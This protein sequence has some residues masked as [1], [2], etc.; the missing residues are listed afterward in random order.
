M[1]LIPQPTGFLQNPL[2]QQLFGNQKEIAVVTTTDAS[3]TNTEQIGLLAGSLQTA[4]ACSD[5]LEITSPEKVKFVTDAVI[6]IGGANN[7]EVDGI[8]VAGSAP[9]NVLYYDTTNQRVT[10]GAT[11]PLGSAWSSIPVVSPANM[12]MNNNDFTN[13]S[14]IGINPAGPLQTVGPAYTANATSQITIT[15]NTSIIDIT[16]S[17]ITLQVDSGEEIRFLAE[18]VL[19]GIGPGN[20]RFIQYQPT[21]VEYELFSAYTAGVATNIANIQGPQHSVFVQA[22]P[23][24]TIPVTP[25]VGETYLTLDSQNRLQWLVH[26]PMQ[27]NPND[28]FPQNTQTTL[29]IGATATG[30]YRTTVMGGDGLIYCTPT[31]T[32]PQEGATIDPTTD[33]VTTGVYSIAASN[34]NPRYC[35]SAGNK[36]YHIP[37]SAI[38]GASPFFFPIYDTITKTIDNSLPAP[39]ANGTGAICGAL[40]ALETFI[41]MPPFAETATVGQR[42]R[43]FDLA[44][45]TTTEIGSNYSSA[46]FQNNKWGTATLAPNGKIYCFPFNARTGGVSQV[47]EIDTTTDTTALIALTGVTSGNTMYYSSCLSPDGNFIYASPTSATHVLK[48]DWRT[49][50]FSQPAGLSVG[51]FGGARYAGLSAAPN[52]L[53]YMFPSDETDIKVIDP[54]TD[55]FI[56]TIPTTNSGVLGKYGDSCLALNG[57]V[58]CAP[59]SANNAGSAIAAV[60]KTGIPTIPMWMLGPGTNQQ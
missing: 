17:Q 24:T 3:E 39:W 41:Y 42:V 59:F 1:A 53:I 14:V 23:N 19:P 51:A 7:L 18:M 32:S 30:K 56:A 20:N 40:N 60:V 11:P 34:S 52:G 8:P 38:V 49:N 10:Y 44:T 47:L 22:S 9:T 46:T 33:T 15:A 43:K 45:Q 58:Y 48:F 27:Y 54:A 6:R 50:T 26:N 16:P 36:I 21:G 55:T 31:N 57:K 12:M 28:M 4:I 35:V 13:A 29:N 5:D 25:A 37:L 2:N